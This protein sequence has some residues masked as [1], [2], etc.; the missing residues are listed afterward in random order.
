ME[1][2]RYLT[3]YLTYWLFRKCRFPAISGSLRDIVPQ[4][5]PGAGLWSQRSVPP[6]LAWRVGERIRTHRNAWFSSSL[7][8][9]DAYNDLGTQFWGW[10]L[11]IDDFLVPLVIKRDQQT[12]TQLA[13][14]PL[15]GSYLT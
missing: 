3:E 8:E 10:N 5:G 4:R 15:Q 9:S 1:Y 2:V 14:A 7:R 13:E 12:R 11:P 6:A